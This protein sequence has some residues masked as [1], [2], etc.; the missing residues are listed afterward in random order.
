MPDTER[1]RP[2]PRCTTPLQPGLYRN[3]PLGR[4][5]G[6]QGSLLPRRD[7][8]RLLG[9]MAADLA[10]RNVDLDETIQPVQP[11]EGALPCPNC[12]TPMQ[13]FRYLEAVNVQPHACDACEVLWAAQPELWTMCC[14]YQLAERQDAVMQG[15][16]AE[17]QRADVER[18]VAAPTRVTW[19][20]SGAGHTNVGQLLD[21]VTT[22]QAGWL[23]LG[24]FAAA[25][26]VLAA[27]AIAKQPVPDWLRLAEP[28]APKPKA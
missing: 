25:G 3:V 9:A 22:A 4:C 13:R 5:P 26:V 14:L 6:C 28:P 27:K 7:V 1:P 20:N 2:C 23:A 16:L 8:Q 12:R 18:F 21:S 17:I 10:A 11:L 19:S 24:L 15:E